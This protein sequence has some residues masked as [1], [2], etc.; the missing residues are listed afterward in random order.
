V[1]G[2]TNTTIGAASATGVNT[3]TSAL[4]S[5]NVGVDEIVIADKVNKA[6]ATDGGSKNGKLS[7][8]GTQK[9]SKMES[10]NVD[11]AGEPDKGRLLAI[12]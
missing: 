2:D 12:V 10:L 11:T 7:A 6:N 1:G 5:T 4:Q 8:S 9:D 3:Q